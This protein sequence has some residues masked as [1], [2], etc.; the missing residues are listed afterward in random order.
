L[1]RQSKQKLGERELDIMQAL[2]KQGS[3]TVSEVHQS[4]LAER[5]DVAYTTIQTML[6]RLEAKGLVTRDDS[7]RA[8]RYR[9][10]LK[11]NAAVNGAIRKL[12][13]R[14]FSGSVEALATRL[15]EKDLSREQLDRVQELIDA[16]R[17]KGEANR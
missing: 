11:E 5:R 7:D 14:F 15:V 4:L 9:P 1:K 8:H 17:R 10:V 6:N 13:E 2:W 16:H 12:A 3:A